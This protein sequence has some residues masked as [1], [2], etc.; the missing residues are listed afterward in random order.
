MDLYLVAGAGAATAPTPAGQHL[1]TQRPRRYP[2]DTSDAEWQIMAEYIPAGG[3]TTKGGR[4]VSYPRRD[5]VDAIRYVDRTGCRWPALPADFQ[6]WQT[7]Y[8]YFRKWN[9]DGT[10]TRMHDG[11]RARLRL[12]EGRTADPTAAAADSQ[13][14][15]AAETVARTSRGYDAGNYPGRVVMPGGGLHPGCRQPRTPLNFEEP[16]YLA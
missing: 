1:P 8:Y 16:R 6:P 12:A 15:R 2:S 3:T 4:P 5:I 10:L 13:S 11:L 7:V 9:R 14:V